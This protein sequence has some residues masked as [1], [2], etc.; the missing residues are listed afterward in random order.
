MNEY[1]YYFFLQRFIAECPDG[2]GDDD[3]VIS[4]IF[5]DDRREVDPISIAFNKMCAW[6]SGRRQR[7]REAYQR[8]Q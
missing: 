6:V 7:R 5:L 3:D 4:S 8:I 2:D 1:D